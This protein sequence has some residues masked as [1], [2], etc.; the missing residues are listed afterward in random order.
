M[1][2][3]WKLCGCDPDGLFSLILTGGS[4]PGQ[5]QTHLRGQLSVSSE[6]N[7]QP[8]ECKGKGHWTSVCTQWLLCQNGYKCQWWFSYCH[9]WAQLRPHMP[10]VCPLVSGLS[11]A[12][13][14]S[15][16][17]TLFPKSNLDVDPVLVAFQPVLSLLSV[18]PQFLTS[19]LP[20]YF[21]ALCCLTV[22]TF[23]T[24]ATP[25]VNNR[26][27]TLLVFCLGWLPINEQNLCLFLED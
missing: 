26:S 18:R 3:E 13:V 8:G 9:D 5:A 19:F 23:K 2:A 24:L 15:S 12:M 20:L 16:F 6:K 7:N 22:R 27:M 11:K 14:P 25:A 1:T 21:D 10:C 17:L 4:P